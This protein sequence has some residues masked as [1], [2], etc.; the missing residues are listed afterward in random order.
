MHAGGYNEARGAFALPLPPQQAA[1]LLHGSGAYDVGD[2][3]EQ[4][5]PSLA[6]A[7]RLS[8]GGL[9]DIRLA[10]NQATISVRV[11]A[12]LPDAAE[13]LTYIGE[14]GGPTCDAFFFDMAAH[15][16]TCPFQRLLQASRSR[17]VIQLLKH[18]L[19]CSY[20]G[21]FI[22]EPVWCARD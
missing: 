17:H 22:M 11:T 14:A 10:G 1:E 13:G 6:A 21:L 15:K 3:D 8:A 4:S 19:C 7:S 5:P 20:A 2:D 9:A 12:A 16:H 18:S